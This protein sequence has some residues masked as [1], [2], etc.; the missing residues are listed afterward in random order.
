M[1][2]RART[3]AAALL[4][5][6]AATLA[7]GLSSLPTS[8]AEPTDPR[9]GVAPD[10]RPNIV[11]ILVDDMRTDEL[12]WM[13]D[14][15]RLMRAGGVAFP[16]AV[17][18]HPQCCPSRA[19]LLTGQY[20]HNH[21]VQHNHGPFG[22]IG[23]MHDRTQTVGTWL[24]DAGYQTAYVGKYLNGYTGLNTLEP[25][26]TRWR[27]LTNVMPARYTEFEFYGD[28]APTEG[29]ITTAVSHETTRAVH[30]FAGQ[31]PFFLY[32]NHT[33]PHD[34][35]TSTGRH[36]PPPAPVY[37]D[38]HI[39]NAEL[40]FLDNPAWDE[41]DVRDLPKRLRADRIDRARMISW[42]KARARALMSVDDAVA[43]VFAALAQTGELADTWVIF[44]SD[45]GYLLGEHR[46]KGKNLLFAEALSVPLLARGPG[47]TE[48]AS[49]N[50]RA[51][52][53]DLPA[54]FV[55]LAEASAAHPLD[56]N[57]LVPALTGN[58][59]TWRDTTLVQ[60]GRVGTN[61]EQPGWQY[62]GVQTARYLYAADVNADPEGDVLFDRR[63]DPY[64]LRN[65]ADDPRY[66][67]VVAELDRRRV[68][69]EGCAGA[70][71]NRRF[72]PLPKPE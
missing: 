28:G 10:D 61:G 25:G 39:A 21:G 60:T 15:V 69:L 23:A 16:R 8:A 40:P 33:A 71:C 50:L 11:L 26:W 1:P 48:T 54:T 22:G 72:G 12:V 19:G 5:P 57:S 65:V 6:L 47:V 45:N 29:Y 20:A 55:D 17:A 64:E 37:A 59:G 27:A 35:R 30:Q 24:Q 56:G 67:A 36:P 7:A 34:Q 53:L 13:E 70:D 2:P 52:L 43:D 3:I 32:V 66:A 46:L 51:S 49:S 4:L 42:A 14:T 31:Q 68:V 18:P 62:R 41:S 63:R 38:E 58:A 9:L 44:T